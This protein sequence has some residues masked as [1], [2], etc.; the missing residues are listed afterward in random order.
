MHC[1]ADCSLFFFFFDNVPVTPNL[2]IDLFHYTKQVSALTVSFKE[3]TTL[4][5]S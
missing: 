4:L 1:T 3:R 2:Q 5:T